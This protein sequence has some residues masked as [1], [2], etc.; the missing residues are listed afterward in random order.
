MATDI[1]IIADKI[2][3]AIEKQGINQQILSKRS[4]VSASAISKILRLETR[5]VQTDTLAAIASG[6]GITRDDLLGS[7][8]DKEAKRLPAPKFWYPRITW[9]QALIW[10]DGKVELDKDTEYFPLY[11]QP[12]PKTFVLTMKGES[13]V[14]KFMPGYIL[15]ID[16]DAPYTPD[17]Y[18]L[19]KTKDYPLPVLRHLIFESGKR[20]LRI[21]NTSFGKE[22][23]EVSKDDVFIGKL[24]A[25]FIPTP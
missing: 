6:L 5:A 12:G 21:I 22:F 18:V 24:R 11:F 8:D 15:F 10:N 13:M 19:V 17:S 9:E 4:G 20:Y 2:K 7:D 3:K 14:P 16:P 1:E 25:S 23:T